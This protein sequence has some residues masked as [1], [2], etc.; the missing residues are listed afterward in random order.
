MIPDLQASLMCDDVRQE[1]NGKFMLIGLFDALAVPH[2]PAIFQKICVVNRWCC[3]E[4]EF[5]QRSRILGPDSDTVLV[6]GKAVTIKLPDPQ[7]TATSVEL[8]L[9]ARFE[10]PGTYWVEILLGNELILRYPL[11]ARLITA[12]H[13]TS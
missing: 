7:A 6:E 3:G 2:F 10:K 9:N 8:F 13:T 5:I 1:R 11:K 12:S 4:G